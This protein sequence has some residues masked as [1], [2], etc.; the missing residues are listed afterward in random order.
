MYE[1][2]N[3]IDPTSIVKFDINDYIQK[4]YDNAHKTLIQKNEYSSE[5]SKEQIATKMRQLSIELLHIKGIYTTTLN[6]LFNNGH[7]HTHKVSMVDLK[8]DNFKEFGQQLALFHYCFLMKLKG[9]SI[10]TYISNLP[11]KPKCISLCKESKL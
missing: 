6:R 5:Y 9:Y 7:M 2:L 3:I 11:E 8:I 1:A 10:H 4:V